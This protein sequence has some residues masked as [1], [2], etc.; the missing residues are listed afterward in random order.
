MEKN[1][2]V[3]NVAVIAHIDHG[4]TTLIDALLKQ[5]HVF[6][7]NE[8]EMG[9][10]RIMDSND[11]ERERGITIVAKNCAINYK[12]VK[13]N[14]IDTPG[15]ADFSGEVERTLGMAE[16]A[17]LIVDAQE[18]P[19]PQTRFVLRTALSLGLKPIVVI[20]KIDKK[21]ARIPF[22][23]DK[24]ESLFLELATDES[25]LNFPV[26]YA[27][28]RDGKVFEN[29]PADFNTKGD[30]TPLLEKIIESVPEP[31]TKD[32]DFKMLVSSFSHDNHLGRVL[33]GK[34]HSGSVAKGKKVIVA[35]SP[36]KT[37]TVEK[38]FV[39]E[40]IDKKEVEE[41][42]AGDIV[43]IAGVNAE[44][45]DTVSTPGDTVALPKI[46]VG[47]P[48]IHIVVGPN[49]SP[50]MGREAEFSTGRQIEERLTKELEKNLSL[51]VDKQPDGRYRVS[52]RGEL[53]LA[54]LLEN[55]RREGFE[56]E[57]EEPQIITKQID[58]VLCEPVEEL[59]IIVPTEYTGVVNQELGK[60]FQTPVKTETI[61]DNEIEFIY[62]IPTRAIMG[63][64][65]ILLTATKGTVLFNS[66]VVG[67][68]PMGK[69]I[70][71]SRSGVLIASQSGEALSYGLNAAQQRGITFIAPGT[72]V[73]E[74]MIVGKNAKQEDIAVNVCK[75]KQLTNMRSKSSD[76]ITVLAPPTVLS[77][78]QSLD[79]IE[80][81][82]LLEI[83][84]ESL[85]LR[86]KHLSEL[87][88]RRYERKSRK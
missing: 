18:G 77:L 21:Y 65:N 71:K 10:E 9:E 85:R 63:L 78:E 80:S 4:K 28:G 61:G 75:G 66:Q 86:K 8:E 24:T 42:S 25:Q 79:F 62:H 48:T 58:G 12:A 37:Y 56:M 2:N 1:K 34:I 16:G 73:Y 47:D 50:F 23:L 51:R 45:G 44:I 33:V 49:T 32:E 82:E 22:V 59:N 31:E 5:T 76:G 40:G 36:E 14:I 38:V 30:I 88:R 70:A 64:R 83:T 54:V 74:G 69:P 29:V 41:V 35:T 52:G 39:A 20:N 72:K 27:V 15:H 81:D 57:V 60:R 53:H 6:R 43:M 17:I 67:Y 87:D 19:M 55:M 84:P 13:I 11:L 26:L 68:E 7:E 46:K 3:R